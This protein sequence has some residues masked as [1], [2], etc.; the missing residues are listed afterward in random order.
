MIAATAERRPPQ[1]GKHSH[2]VGTPMKKRSL[3][4][5]GE[6]EL[7]VLQIVWELGTA[8]VND[9]RDRIS[10]SRN[11]AYT[12][13]MTVMRNLTDKGYLEYR[14]DGAAYLYSAKQTREEVSSQ[15]LDQLV[16]KIFD[17]SSSALVQTLVKRESLTNA[18]RQEILHALAE[19]DKGES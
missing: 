1:S 18:E 15:I 11:I 10:Q 7:E 5:L 19:L 17:G 14:K 9:V 2:V 8:S 13:V 4:P 16:G 3:F 12:T 6:T